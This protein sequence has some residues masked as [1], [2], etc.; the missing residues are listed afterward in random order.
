MNLMI[1]VPFGAFGFLALRQDVRTS[2]VATV[3]LL[4]GLALSSSIEMIQLFDDRR[5]CTASDLVLNVSGTAV[6]VILG[7]LYQ[8]WL[9]RLLARTE[10]SKLLR[11]SGAILL[12]YT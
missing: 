4:L 2:V 8:Q 10:T 7:C 11:P 6:G 1:F 5:E 12:S 3:T 9:K